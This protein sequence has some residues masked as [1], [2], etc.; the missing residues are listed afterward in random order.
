MAELDGTEFP[1]SLLDAPGDALPR[2]HAGRPVLRVEPP[3]APPDD[4]P[5]NGW[6]CLVGA[7]DGDAR[8][9]T[10]V[11]YGAPDPDSDEWW[12]L[13]LVPDGPGWRG[14]VGWPTQV[15]A[16]LTAEDLVLEL[17]GEG[18]L[19]PEDLQDLV[20][21][22]A[23]RDGEALTAESLPRTHVVGHVQP[24]DSSVPPEPVP[25]VV[26]GPGPRATEDRGRL[27]IPVQWAQGRTPAPG[28][29]AH[30]V[31]LTLLFPK[32]SLRVGLVVR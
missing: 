12:T 11:V 4:V 29:G 14:V 7:D 22:V 28:P 17:S 18:E 24:T 23:R 32:V 13:Q 20:V 15:V 1:A 25:F 27:R 19:H 30:E 26:S 3:P 10:T 2:E 9:G 21:W 16:A 8:G 6:R 31:V 5:E